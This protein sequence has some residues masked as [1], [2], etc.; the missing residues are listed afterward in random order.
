MILQRS[1]QCVIEIDGEMFSLSDERIEPIVTFDNTSHD[2]YFVSD[3]QGTAISR[4]TTIESPVKYIDVMVRKNLQESGEFDEPLSV[5]THWKKKK[6]R[7][8]TDILF[9][10]LPTRILYQY[11]ERIK[12]YQDSV[13]LFPL[14]SVL[15]S[16]LKKMEPK[17]PVAIVFQH[18]RFAD[19]I[20]GTHKRVYYANRCVAF[21]DTDEQIEVLWN[22]ART[23]IETAKAE[24]GIEINKILKLLWIGSKEP[25]AWPEDIKGASHP[26]PEADFT[27]PNGEHCYLPFIAAINAL[28]GLDGVSPPR[29]KA[30]YYTNRY[31]P[32]CN[33]F[34]LL[35]ILFVLVGSVWCFYRD[36][37]IRKEIA[38]MEKTRSTVLLSL[39]EKMPEISY[40]DSLS[41][42]R[43]LTYSQKVP[44]YKE[45][46]NDLSAALSESMKIENLKVEYTK[47]IVTLEILGRADTSFKKAYVGYQTFGSYLRDKGY[48]V[49]ESKFSTEISSSVFFMKLRKKIL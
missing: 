39:S 23:D 41:L 47:K 6:G 22:T 2:T 13:I 20:I 43:D 18:N 27:S 30:L 35:S 3:M 8:V 4:T 25:P 17:E 16:I 29:E 24:Y 45:A 21:D 42:V 15:F 48:I 26:F 46:I 28:S 19:V 9:T 11:L 31:A 5:I 49:E 37:V 10:A 1:K 7:N 36:S 44:S 38:T 33:A 40:E 32:Y 14:Y 12:A 34:L